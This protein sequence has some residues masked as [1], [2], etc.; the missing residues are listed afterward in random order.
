MVFI[1]RASEVQILHEIHIPASCMDM[2]DSIILL[3]NNFISTKGRNLA[4]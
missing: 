1:R 4:F 2:S 3:A